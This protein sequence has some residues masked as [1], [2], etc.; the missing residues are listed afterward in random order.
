[1]IC[2]GGRKDRARRHMKEKNLDN[3]GPIEALDEDA[4][5]EDEEDLPRPEGYSSVMKGFRHYSSD[6]YTI[7]IIAS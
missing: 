3:R 6:N 1:M 4:L 2:D 5:D 7:I